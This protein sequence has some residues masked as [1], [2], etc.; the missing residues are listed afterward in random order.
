MD[1]REATAGTSRRDLG[2][3]PY[4]GGRADV[5]YGGDGDIYLQASEYGS[6]IYSN[7]DYS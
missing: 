5:G 4:G 6:A 2:L 3:P 7:S 1:F